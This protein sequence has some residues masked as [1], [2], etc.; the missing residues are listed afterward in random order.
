MI[1]ILL[2]LMLA[3]ATIVVLRYELEGS[4]SRHE[5]RVQQVLDRLDKLE[6]LLGGAP[7]SSSSSSSISKQKAPSKDLTKT[8]PKPQALPS[9]ALSSSSSSSPPSI[10][11]LIHRTWFTSNRYNLS[12]TNPSVSEW[13]EGWSQRNPTH[14]QIIH[15]DLESEKF[16]RH[17]FQGTDV[18]RAFFKLPMVVQR[19]DFMRYVMLWEFGGVYADMDTTCQVPIE[20]W[21]SN[22]TTSSNSDES[23][24]IKFIVGLEVSFKTPKW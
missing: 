15:D 7:T 10:P 22:Y 16:I 9:W 23:D 17:R 20:S 3:T 13:F 8:K 4:T 11:N 19:S 12:T 14:V 24:D 21:A 2:V 6:T 18:E 1:P 5:D